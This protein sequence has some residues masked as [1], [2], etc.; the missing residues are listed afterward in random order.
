MSFLKAEWR[1][2]LMINYEID[3]KILEPYVPKGTKLDFFNNKCY[4]S[5]V[6]FMFLNTKLLGVKVPFHVNFEE[7]NLRFYVKREENEV[8]KR[9]VVFIKE[10]V[11]KPAITFV[12][13]TIYNEHYETL[14]MEHHWNITDE[15]LEVSY[16]WK[17]YKERNQIA[18]KAKNRLEE[19]PKGSEIEFIAEHYWGYSQ[20]NKHETTAY[21]VKHPSWKYYPVYQSEVKVNFIANY[22]EDFGFLTIQ[23][24]SSVFLLEGSEVSVENKTILK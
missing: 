16:E 5:V 11:P 23:K 8:I 2:L 21:E 22:G 7:I 15:F 19:I 24:P 13:N 4:V 20:K 6:G 17:K 10:I 1:K 14:P 18:A 12:A 9:G 3:P